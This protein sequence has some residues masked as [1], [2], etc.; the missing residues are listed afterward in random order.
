MSRNQR[1]S[2]RDVL[3]GMGLGVGAS[4]LPFLPLTEREAEAQDG[5]LKRLILITS[6]NGTVLEDWRPL[7]N[8]NDFTL[9]PILAPLA[10]HKDRL[11]I[12][13]GIDEQ[14]IE[15]GPG[16][17]HDA[18][19]TMFT[20]KPLLDTHEFAGDCQCGWASD[21]SVDQYIASQIAAPTMLDSLQVGIGRTANMP[22]ARAFHAGPSQPLPLENSPA[23]LFERLFEDLTLDPEAA[24]KKKAERQSVLDVLEEEIDAVQPKLGAADKHKLDRHLDAIHGIEAQ[25]DS[26]VGAN[27]EIGDAPE[28]LDP[29]LDANIQQITDLQLSLITEAFACDLTRVV[30]LQ[31]GRE[32]STGNASPYV[33]GWSSG[34]IHE[35]SHEGTV[36]GK[37][38]MSAFNAYLAEH[39]VLNL[40][41]RLYAIPEAGGTMLDHT[42]VVW[43]LPISQGW[44]HSNQNIPVVI[45]TGDQSYFKTGRY[46][47]YGSY[48]G[49]SPP[50]HND[51]GGEAMNKV[52]VSLCRAMGLSDVDA[53]GDPSLP[54]GELP[55]ATG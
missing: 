55:G 41:D 8:E 38:K 17:G 11:L 47:R 26:A 34:G 52:L 27:C 15:I 54:T 42:I 5:Q 21:L 4:M 44:T 13:D 6:P 20:G 43:A 9:S 32:G 10:P 49:S 14:A 23:D 31:W 22:R 39:M 35:V 29:V 16:N 53:F 50:Y 36:E 46:L 3:R 2:R 33:P 25:L 12:L 51:H 30:G 1:L 28:D 37:A 45:A 19:A 24:A 18:L 48:D 40:L 7:G